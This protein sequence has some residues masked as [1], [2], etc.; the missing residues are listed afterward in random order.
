MY[1]L[2]WRSVTWRPGTRRILREKEP[3]PVSAG[4]DRQTAGSLRDR[5][6]SAVTLPVGLRPPYEVT[7][8][9]L[10]LIAAQFSP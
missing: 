10:I 2:I 4:R 6:L 3:I 8:L 7:A 1:S 5:A 9:I